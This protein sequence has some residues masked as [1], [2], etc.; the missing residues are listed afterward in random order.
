MK[1][2][3]K[4]VIIIAKI[5][6][7]AHWVA[8]GILAVMIA[9][10]AAGRMQFLKYLSD[11]DI[12]S[13]EVSSNGFT[14][15]LID[16]TGKLIPGALILFFITILLVCILMAMIFRNVYLIFKTSEG[17]TKFSQGK[18]PFQKDNIRMVREIGIFCIAIPVVEL[19]V[20]VIA[21]IVLPVG[22]VE[23]SVE[24]TGVFMGLVVLCLSQFF[25]YGMELQEDV[26]GLV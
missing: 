16:S 6:E 14:I 19:I 22:V 8:A 2:L 25:A 17:E 18:T 21:R 12:A 4:A 23:T 10:T 1:R 11:V 3:N 5:C 15:G 9:V 20:S 24:M 26:D 13:K 7:I